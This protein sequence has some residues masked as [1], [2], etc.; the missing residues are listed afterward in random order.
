MW[1]L[2]G[3]STHNH[4][5]SPTDPWTWRSRKDKD[6]PVN[7]EIWDMCMFYEIATTNSVAEHKVSTD[8]NFLHRKAMRTLCGFWLVF[9][10]ATSEAA[11]VLAHVSR[12][13]SW[14]RA[15]ASRSSI[16]TRSWLEHALIIGHKHAA[17]NSDEFPRK[18]VHYVS[19][20]VILL[21]L[22]AC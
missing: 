5:G 19:C 8:W 2:M 12:L 18:T 4:Q 6:T 13:G 10:V 1:S 11:H 15:K 21:E 7:W 14:I 17:C 9:W 16:T 20:A 3:S 22:N